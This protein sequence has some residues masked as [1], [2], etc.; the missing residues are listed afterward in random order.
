MRGALKAQAT[1]QGAGFR[2]LTGTVTVADAGGADA[3]P[4]CSASRRPSGS[5]GS[6][7]DRD[8]ARGR[9]QLAFGQLRRDRSTTSTKADVILSLDAD[10]LC[11]AARR[12]D[13]ATPRAFADAPASRGRHP[14]S[15][16][17]LYVVESDAT[18]TGAKADHRLPLRAAEIEAVRARHR[19][20]AGARRRRAAAHGRDGTQN[21][22]DAVVKDLQAAAAALWWWPANTSRPRCTR[23]RTR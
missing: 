11:T 17:R 10:F 7:S 12:R 9:R 16:N 8:S 1:T 4:C 15:M 14:G 23:W 19:R 13:F 3:R 18:N 6:R 22:I 21:W 5:S 20:Q 2:I